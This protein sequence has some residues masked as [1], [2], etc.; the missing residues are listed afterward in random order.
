MPISEELICEIHR[1]IITDCDEDH[2]APGRIRP[3]DQKR[4][5]WSFLSHRGVNAAQSAAKPSNVS[6]MKCKHIFGAQPAEDPKTLLRHP[7]LIPLIHLV[8]PD[9]TANH[10]PQQ[11]L[12]CLT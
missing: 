12:P 11:E 3:A 6:R 5:L 2:C 4:D 7:S 1:L 8:R 10:D 9:Y